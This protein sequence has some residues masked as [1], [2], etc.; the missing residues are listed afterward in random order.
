MTWTRSGMRTVGVTL[1]HAAA[2]LAGC[3]GG[4]GSPGDTPSGTSPARSERHIALGGQPNFRDLGGYRTVNGL[5][6]RWGQ[7]YRSGE[8]G[9]CTKEDVATLE[10]LDLQTVVNFLLPEEIER[11][12]PDRL[13]EA[14]RNVPA[15]I[16]SKR[17][18]ELTRQVQDSIRY[19]RSTG[20][21]GPY[22]IG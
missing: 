16:S 4:S 9:Q 19:Q 17:A 21:P 2:V 15:A 11:H 8:L 22:G 5:T 20:W 6:V 14:T 7:V 18:A 3:S 13:P 10:S 12:G 1:A